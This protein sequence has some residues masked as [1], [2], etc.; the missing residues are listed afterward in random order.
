MNKKLLY[1]LQN[2]QRTIHLIYVICEMN[3]GSNQSA[4]LVDIIVHGQRLD[5]HQLITLLAG[6]VW[7]TV[8]L[9]VISFVLLILIL[10]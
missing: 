5:L 10:L 7:G 4:V 8:D 6:L 9:E 1:L 3:G 2:L